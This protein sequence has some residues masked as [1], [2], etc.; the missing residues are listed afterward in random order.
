MWK[1][2]VWVVTKIESIPQTWFHG[3]GFLL[4]VKLYLIE[5][6]MNINL[7]MT[8]IF[9]REGEG[10]IES[11]NSKWEGAFKSHLFQILHFTDRDVRLGELRTFPR[12]IICNQVTW[13]TL[14]VGW[15]HWLEKLSREVISLG[16][17]HIFSG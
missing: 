5:V 17:T 6:S 10:T 13:V 16:D 7:S 11:E 9:T 2:G 1:V 3:T 12:T 14:T 4:S 8:D 15:G